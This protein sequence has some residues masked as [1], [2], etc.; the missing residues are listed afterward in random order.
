MSCGEKKSITDVI[1]RNT[2][3]ILSSLPY[4][5]RI[6]SIDQRYADQLVPHQAESSALRTLAVSARPDPL[7]RSCCPAY[8]STRAPTAAPSFVLY[9]STQNVMYKRTFHW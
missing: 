4:P 1:R 5:L 9:E 6:R 8:S 3:V 2:K 7:T